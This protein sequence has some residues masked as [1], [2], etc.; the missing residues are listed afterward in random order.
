M[1]SCR[2]LPQQQNKRKENSHWTV[3]TH[4]ETDSDNG[5]QIFP[6]SFQWFT[7][8][9]CYFSRGLM[10]VTPLDDLLVPIP[11]LSRR[12]RVFAG[13][14][15]IRKSFFLRNYFPTALS[16]VSDTILLPPSLPLPIIVRVKSIYF[17][18]CVYSVFTQRRSIH[19]LRRSLFFLWYRVVMLTGN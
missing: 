8:F 1:G 10:S 11:L 3:Q 6:F 12:E 4:W 7:L 13:T 5:K 15:E 2:I 17:P 16:I 19:R 14:N 18:I 9:I